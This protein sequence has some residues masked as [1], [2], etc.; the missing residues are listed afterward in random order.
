MNQVVDEKRLALHALAKESVVIMPSG[1]VRIKLGD[2]T[3]VAAS[4]GE[5]SD[6][7]EE[8]GTIVTTAFLNSKRRERSEP[9]ILE[10]KHEP[11]YIGTMHSILHDPET[12][13]IANKVKLINPAKMCEDPVLLV[14]VIDILR[15][16]GVQLNIFNIT[17]AMLR[18]G[19]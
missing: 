18:A 9:F 13:D 8:L 11:Q 17:E 2:K 14:C 15:L 7:I 1:F 19:K 4:M 12:R 6:Y 10:K 3:T 5:T 16:S